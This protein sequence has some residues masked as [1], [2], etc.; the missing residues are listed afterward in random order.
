VTSWAGIAAPKRTPAEVVDKLNATINEA[1]ASDTIKTRYAEMA[2]TLAPGSPAEFGNF[3]A[4]EASK[5]A[6]VVRFAGVKPP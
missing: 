5:W 6:K 1:L 3:I 2:S 4:G